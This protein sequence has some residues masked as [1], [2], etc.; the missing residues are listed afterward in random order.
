MADTIERVYKITADAND[1]IRELNKLNKSVG[2]IDSGLKKAGAVLKGAFAGAAVVGAINAITNAVGNSIDSLDQLGKTTQKLG[3]AAEDFLGLE[4]AANM[5]DIST[6][7]LSASITKLNKAIAASASGETS[8]STEALT[9]LGVSVSDSA[10]RLKNSSDIFTEVAEAFSKLPD[11]AQKAALAMQIFGKSGAE[12]IPLLNE[13]SS[14]LAAF[15]EEAQRLGLIVDDTSA[16]LADQFNDNLDRMRLLSEGATRQFTSGL[17]P[18]LVSVSDEMTEAAAVSDIFRSAGEKL[19]KTLQLLKITWDAFIK[20][21]TF[22]WQGEVVAA[23]SKTLQALNDVSR[24]NPQSFIDAPKKIAEAW[25]AAGANISNDVGAIADDVREQWRI[26]GTDASDLADETRQKYQDGLNSKPVT[27]TVIPKIDTSQFNT[28]DAD[29]LS[30]DLAKT[31]NDFSRKLNKDLEEQNNLVREQAEG[32]R[33]QRDFAREATAS[34]EV[35]STAIGTTLSDSV[36][37]FVDQ[38]AAG[39]F[40]FKKFVSSMVIDIAKLIAKLYILK[41]LQSSTTFG[42]LFASANGSAFDSIGLKQGVYTTPQFFPM[43]GTGRRYFANGGVGVMAEAGPEAIMPLKR[44]SDGR[45]GVEVKGSAGNINIH[46]YADAQVTAK[47]NGDDI[48]IIVDRIAADVLRGGTKIS[49]ALE[50]TYSVN[51]VRA[52]Q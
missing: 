50:G 38:I 31:Q 10:G 47:R 16:V 12:L 9:K 40:T 23:V 11:G 34:T 13:G 45:L 24:F 18:A 30:K 26:L 41:A 4:H 14:G 25:S 27:V 2:S 21:I 39:G 46:N 35:L 37:S 7:K 28:D 33:A 22:N 19:G 6:E 51:R 17:L 52:S 32:L 42:G 36:G 49:R 15:N 1:A 3:I 48:E 43:A 5:T 8:K 44:G 29:R 20:V